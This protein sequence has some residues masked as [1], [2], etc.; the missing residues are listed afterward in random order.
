[1]IFTRALHSLC[2]GFGEKN[3][4]RRKMQKLVSFPAAVSSKHA[5]QASCDSVLFRKF[6][7]CIY[8]HGNFKVTYS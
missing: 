6:I 7:V 1:M 5:R 3:T 4:C 2:K 8:I